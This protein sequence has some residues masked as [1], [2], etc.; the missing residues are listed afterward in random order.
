MLP[1]DDAIGT[2][3]TVPDDETVRK[4]SFMD[5]VPGRKEEGE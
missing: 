2:C 1:D 4:Y 3:F 5:H